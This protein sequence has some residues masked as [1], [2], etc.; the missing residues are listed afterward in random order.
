MLILCLAFLLLFDLL[1]LWSRAVSYPTLPPPASHPH[2]PALL[3]EF[4]LIAAPGVSVPQDVFWR[5]A[6]WADDEG[7]LVADLIPE[8]WAPSDVLALLHQ[9][10]P[11]DYAQ[12]PFV[13]GVS[14]GMAVVVH[15]SI[16]QRHP[17]P[18]PQSGLLG[19]IHFAQDLK[20][21]APWESALVIAQGWHHPCPVLDG[22][23][24]RASIKKRFGAGFDQAKWA[25]PI[26][27]ALFAWILSYDLWSGIGLI[28]LWMAQPAFILGFSSPFK[29]NWLAYS[30]GRPL[31]DLKNW[32]SLF[33]HLTPDPNAPPQP[34]DLEDV[35]KEQLQNGVAPFFEERLDHC[36]WCG[37]DQLSTQMTVPDFYQNKP[38]YFSLD[39]CIQCHHIFQNPRLSIEGLQFYYQDFY[40]GLGEVGMDLVFGA[41]EVSYRQRVA[42]I[43]ANGAP[44]TWLDVGGGHGHF[45]L[46]AKHLLPQTH[47]DVLDLSESVTIAE[48]RGWIQKG[49]KGLF[50]D[51][52]DQLKGKYDGVSMSHYLEHTRDP[53]AEI[54]AAAHVLNPGGL[55]MIEVPDPESKFGQLLKSFWLPWFQPQHQHFVSVANLTDLFEAEGFEVIDLDRSAAH[56]SVDFFFAALILI[57]KWAPDPSRP[58]MFDSK[59]Q[60]QWMGIKRAFCFMVG[61]P[62]LILGTLLD[63]LARPFFSR[64]YWSNTYRILGK[65]KDDTSVE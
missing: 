11:I 2:P 22:P 26:L 42:M 10:H 51:L 8:G 52:V 14:G 62:L 12:K 57:Q 46:I 30:L 63:R 45:A 28:L 20:R 54:K 29:S 65:K 1:R 58:W 44:R 19:W 7:V 38:G 59:S 35:Y 13:P 61:I 32:S 36:P 60:K 18:D 64:P 43:R 40:D 37:S 9:T 55:L 6:Q 50:P 56:Q 34:E 53:K 48:K 27:F 4:T 41:S 31:I 3:D 17:K 23:D 47:F 15:D 39:Q 33:G 25:T 49:I 5:A 21:F 24:R 16:L